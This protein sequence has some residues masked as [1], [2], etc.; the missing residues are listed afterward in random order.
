MRRTSEGMQQSSRLR[1]REAELA[2]PGGRSVTFH[3]DDEGP[4]ISAGWSIPLYVAKV[5]LRA[6]A[7]DEAL[8]GPELLDGFVEGTGS[9]WELKP[10][11]RDDLL[12]Q[13]VPQPA[14]AAAITSRPP[15]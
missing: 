3:F 15:R 11:D 5:G 8:L 2:G 9:A 1:S 4:G 6:T 12:V 10:W 7:P 13:T 14:G